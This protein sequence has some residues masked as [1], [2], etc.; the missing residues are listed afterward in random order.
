M[1]SNNEKLVQDIKSVVAD[2]EAVLSATSGQVGEGVAELRTAM[3]AR[4]AD[5]K[6]RLMAMEQAL[7]DKAKQA[8]KGT[9]EYVH[10]NPWQS[11]IIA[12]GVGFL[13]GY[14]VSSRRD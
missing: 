8:A 4:L 2:A 7:V 5:A 6:N 12:G 13:I 14:L 11:V 3:T 1:T 10:E 9:D